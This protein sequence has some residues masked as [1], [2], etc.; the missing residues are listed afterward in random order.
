M[1]TCRVLP[2]PRILTTHTR[3]GVSSSLQTLSNDR[4]EKTCRIEESGGR[5]A[6]CKGMR[7]ED[8]GPQRV[9]LKR[10]DV[11]GEC[12]IVLFVLGSD[13]MRT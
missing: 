1:N 3:P 10:Q 8:I 9:W 5:V 2:V 7:G 6:A 11:P 13:I 4:L 12:E